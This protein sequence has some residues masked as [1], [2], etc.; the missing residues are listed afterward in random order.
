MSKIDYCGRRFILAVMGSAMLSGVAYGQAISKVTYQGQTIKLAHRYPDFDAYKDDPENLT[1]AEIERVAALVRGA[2]IP[3]Q[4][5]TREQA[6]EYLYSEI[7]FPG[8]GLSLMQLDKPVAL[9]SVEIPQMD[10]DRWITMVQKDDKWVV[11][12]DFEWPTSKG[13]I[14]QAVVEDSRIRYLDRK[15]N[16]LRER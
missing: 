5:K 16:T 15:G 11:I 9:F 7:M 12:D 2:V 4:F 3:Q 13:Y 1:A 8:Y 6:G 10:A 14:Q